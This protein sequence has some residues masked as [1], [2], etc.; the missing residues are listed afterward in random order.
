MRRL[1]ILFLLLLSACG[2]LVPVATPTLAPPTV[3]LT[4]TVVPTPAI[5]PSAPDG[6]TVRYHPDG[7]LYAGDVISIEIITP[8][9]FPTNGEQISVA[10]PNAVLGTEKFGGYGIADRK[11]AT[12]WWVWDTHALDAG[13]YTLDFSIQPV[14]NEWQETIALLPSDDAPDHGAKWEVVSTACCTI[15]YIT[16]TQA[17]RDLATLEQMAEAQ[18]ADVAQKLR[19]PFTEPIQIVF[20]PRTLGHGGFASDAIYV[21]YL[22]RNYAGSTTAFVLHHEMAHWLDRKMG[23]DFLPTVFLEGLAV[24]VTGGHFKPEPLG[25]RAAALFD[26]GW[27]IPLRQL[28]DDFYPSQHEVGY[29]EAGALI[30]YLVDTY[31]WDAFNAFYRD[32][33][34]APDQSQSGAIDP[35]LIAHFNLSFDQLEENFSA[36]LKGQAVTEA[37]RADVRLTVAFYDTVRR[38]QRMLDPSAYFMTAWLP[39]GAQMRQRN[40]VADFTRHPD[41]AVNQGL[42]NLLIEADQALRAGDYSKA[43]EK[44]QTVNVFLDILDNLN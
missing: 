28:A 36:Y 19:A 4:P 24:Y 11:Q 2:P 7:P 42:E 6:F 16:G 43:E 38:Y 22:D 23:G 5:T 39:D 20:M 32:I 37:N 26:L 1:S 29:L 17:E 18:S 44:I 33:H 27:Y 41:S 3:T 30:E 14:G 34:A 35:A 8:A 15:N 21:S 13:V 10:D 12:L 25:A 9:N 31:G 40:I